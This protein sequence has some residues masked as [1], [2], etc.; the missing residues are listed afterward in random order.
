MELVHI[1]LTKLSM[2]SCLRK[3]KR[4]VHAAVTKEFIQ[5]HT[6]EA[7]GPLKAE[8]TTDDKKSTR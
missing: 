7:F 6:R 2:K 8:D 1:A 5:L 4:K 3:Y